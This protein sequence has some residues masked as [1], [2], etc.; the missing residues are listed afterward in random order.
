MKISTQSPSRPRWE[1]PE[2][3]PG[4]ARYVLEHLG[5]RRQEA[6]VLGQ[7]ARGM[8][9]P[10]LMAIHGAGADYTQ[11]NPVLYGLQQRG[12]GSLAMN[13]SGHSDAGGG[14]PS[15]VNL[16]FN[17]KE[18]LRFGERLK[19]GLLGLLAVDMGA[20]VA[21]Q[22]AQAHAH[23]LHRMVLIDPFFYPDTAFTRPL[24]LVLNCPSLRWEQSRLL[25]FL[26]RYVGQLMVITGE[27]MPL[28]LHQRRAGPVAG[29]TTVTPAEAIARA[30]L[31]RRVSRIT[32]TGCTG[33]VMPWLQTRPD[34][35]NRLNDSIA[36]FLGPA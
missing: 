23:S 7:P 18:A 31:P 6:R 20:M 32:I 10:R 34:V 17:V 36:S 1:H 3:P 2:D 29:G 19:P 8:G 12:T 30:V 28:S 24:S 16:D 25:E 35:A 27:A 33:Q 22:V 15:M 26:Q 13:L 9:R 4:P 14:V 5:F 11:L 21:L